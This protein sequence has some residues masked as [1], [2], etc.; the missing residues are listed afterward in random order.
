MPAQLP[1]PSSQSGRRLFLQRLAATAAGA[2]L[3]PTLLQAC[4]GS[5]SGNG[6]GS[7]EL[8]ISTFPLYIDPDGPGAPGTVSR[9]RRDTGI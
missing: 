3:A 6:N 8:V 7:G 2:V 9:F 5:G 1:L 4:K